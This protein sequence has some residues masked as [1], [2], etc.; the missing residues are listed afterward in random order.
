M[1]SRRFFRLPLLSLLL[2][3][4]LVTS[5]KKDHDQ[6]T[7]H[8]SPY[9]KI[10]MDMMAQMDAQAK[11]QDPDHDFAAQ[12]VL[13]HDA[14]IKM[15]QEEL[16][17]GT[18]QEMKTTAQDIITKQQAEIGQFNAFLGSHQPQ[19]PLVPQFNQLQKTNMDRMMAASDARTLTGRPDYDFAQLM[20][21]HH[22]AAIDNSEALLQHGRNTTTRSMAQAIIADQRQEIAALQNWLTRNR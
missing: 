9:M 16:R 6:H 10:M 13:H 1:L 14:A 18:N 22:Q 17:T 4:V 11:T 21:D 3:G 15:A 19:T 2:I 20:V 8:D 12:M 5:C 7:K